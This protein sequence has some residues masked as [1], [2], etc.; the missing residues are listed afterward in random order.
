[1]HGD[2]L[3]GLNLIGRTILVV[4]DKPL[5]AL[6]IVTAFEKSGAVVVTARSLAQAKGLV[7]QDFSAAV[8]DF[9]P[10]QCAHGSHLVTSHTFYT[11]VIAISTCFMGVPW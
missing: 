4:E 6:D 9:T 8:V 7:E 10:M 11:A 5:I 1:L 3:Q 2:L